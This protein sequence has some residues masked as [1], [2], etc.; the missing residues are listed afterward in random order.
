MRKFIVSALATEATWKNSPYQTEGKNFV[1][2]R[3]ACIC[4]LREVS[5]F[6]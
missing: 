3:V 6:G 2:Y 1:M 5:Y 4:A